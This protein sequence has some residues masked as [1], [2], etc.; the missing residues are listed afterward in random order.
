[1]EY[2]GLTELYLDELVCSFLTMR[3]YVCILE[4]MILLILRIGTPFSYLCDCLLHGNGPSIRSHDLGW[5]LGAT[6]KPIRNNI[7]IHTLL[8]AILPV[9]VNCCHEIKMTLKPSLNLLR[10]EFK[11]LKKLV[12]KFRIHIEKIFY[13]RRKSI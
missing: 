1:M 7:R 9:V 2:L 13:C 10:K 6:T 11:R 5:Y 4:K 8:W 12:I 3:D